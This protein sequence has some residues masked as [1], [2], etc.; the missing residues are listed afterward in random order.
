MRGGEGG[1]LLRE[2]L[3][4]FHLIRRCEK[5]ANVLRVLTERRGVERENLKGLKIFFN[6]KV[7]LV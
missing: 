3:K 2:S 1:K 6:L 4:E 5:V 7:F